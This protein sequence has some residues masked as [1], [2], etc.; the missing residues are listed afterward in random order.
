MR[1]SRNLTRD[2]KR[3]SCCIPPIATTDTSFN[4]VATK[5]ASRD[6]RKR[7]CVGGAKS[8]QTLTKERGWMTRG[9]SPFPCARSPDASSTGMEAYGRLAISHFSTVGDWNAS[10][11]ARRENEGRKRR[12]GE[13]QLGSRKFAF[14]SISLTTATIF[15]R[16]SIV[17]M[18]ADLAGWCTWYLR[19]MLYGALLCD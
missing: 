18:R 15:R 3:G 11:P 7:S 10:G 5:D 6:P 13:D 16:D 12:L 1:T 8:T 14:A 17:H 4:N 2:A 19:K 9:V